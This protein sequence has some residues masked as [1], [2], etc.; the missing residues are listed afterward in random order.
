MER[1]K[2]VDLLVPQFE[3]APNEGFSSSADIFQRK[4]FGENLANQI[5]NSKS[6]LVIG[7][8][9]NWGQGK[10]TFVK[11]WQGLIESDAYKMKSIYFDAFQ[12][13]HHGD[14]F[15]VIASEIYESIDPAQKPSFK[16]KAGA[17]MKAVG[18]VALRVGIKTISAGMFDETVLDKASEEIGQEV[19]EAADK[20]IAEKFDSVRADK[21][22]LSDFKSYLIKLVEEVG[23]GKPIVIIIDELDRCRPDFALNILE[24]IKHF[25]SIPQLVF[26]L[27]LNKTQMLEAIRS[28]YGLDTKAI[29]Y[30]QKF[31]HMWATLPTKN[32]SGTDA[33]KIF[34]LQ[35]L[36]KMQSALSTNEA[37]IFEQLLDLHNL[38]L[39]EVERVITNFAIIRNAG[40]NQL[41]AAM[42]IAPY[43]SI[44]KVKFPAEYM[45]LIEGRISFLELKEATSLKDLPCTKGS[46]WSR[47]SEKH[48]ISWILKYNMLKDNWDYNADLELIGFDFDDREVLQRLLRILEHFKVR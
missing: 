1:I 18:K 26:V 37:K 24:T 38:S 40:A 11:M 10:T 13:D 47:C 17:A 31:V 22:A 41:L 4:E 42:A 6:N 7:L 3:V 25:F 48:P 45:K 36:A 8:E 20:F 44:L 35:C 33:S 12:N 21:K 43:L 27:V 23:G 2:P 29:E 30:L 15:F 39:R 19:S 14:P 5:I 28:K 16:E 32:L 9:S 46:T 34:L